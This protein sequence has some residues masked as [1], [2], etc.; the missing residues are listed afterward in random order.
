MVT[1][2]LLCPDRY[3]AWDQGPPENQRLQHWAE[4][5]SPNCL[6]CTYVATASGSVGAHCVKPSGNREPLPTFGRDVLSGAN[7]LLIG[8][9]ENR[10]EIHERHLLCENEVTMFTTHDSCLLPQSAKA[11]N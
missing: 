6:R 4:R 10:Y 5:Y 9:V 1:W 8:F 3:I 2:R 11:I 7:T